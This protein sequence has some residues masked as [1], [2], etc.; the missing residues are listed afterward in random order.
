MNSAEKATAVYSFPKH[1]NK[2]ALHN[3]TMEMSITN[4]GEYYFK[5]V[6]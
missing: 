6:C 4:E 1:R 2:R 5:P 3:I